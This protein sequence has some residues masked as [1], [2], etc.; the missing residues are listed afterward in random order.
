MSAIYIVFGVVEHNKAAA[1]NSLAARPQEGG[2]RLIRC[3]HQDQTLL[4]AAAPATRA[5]VCAVGSH[6]LILVASG[7]IL[8]CA[9][10]LAGR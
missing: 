9:T 1:P 10:P 8:H 5:Y 2:S 4:M 3:L 7:Q 6:S